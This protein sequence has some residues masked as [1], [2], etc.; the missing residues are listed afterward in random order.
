MSDASRRLP[1][2]KLPL[3]MKIMTLQ[4]LS[5][6]KN[7]VLFNCFSKTHSHQT[8]SSVSNNFYVPQVD[9][10][11]KE[12]F[13]YS[14]FVL[15]NNLPED[16]KSSNLSQNVFKSHLKK[17]YFNVLKTKNDDVFL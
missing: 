7:F 17:H 15:W 16:L 4:Y 14:S 9:S 2:S 6:M 13:Y 8:R 10:F 1:F 5:C 11:T 12:T 3:T